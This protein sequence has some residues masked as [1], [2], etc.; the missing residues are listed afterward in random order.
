[1]VEIEIGRKRRCEARTNKE[2]EQEDFSRKFTQD[3][4]I[5][6]PGGPPRREDRTRERSQGPIG[7]PTGYG[8]KCAERKHTERKMKVEM[9]NQRTERMM[10]IEMMNQRTE[11][12]MGIEQ[13]MNQRTERMME[14]E[15]MENKCA[16]RNEETNGR[17]NKCTGCMKELGKRRTKR[18]ERMEKMG[19]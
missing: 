5:Y 15:R 6:C 11:R 7:P 3:R 9:M 13:M 8:K 14:T 1:M 19:K 17:R 10:E 18:M 2:G 12:M 16:E 4:N